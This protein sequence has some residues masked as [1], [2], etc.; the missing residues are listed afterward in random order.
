[1]EP[2][3]EALKGKWSQEGKENEWTIRVG[4][5][6]SGGGGRNTCVPE[7]R[8]VGKLLE[9]RNANVLSIGLQTAPMEYEMLF[10]YFEL[11]FTLTVEKTKNRQTYVGMGRGVKMTLLRVQIA[12]KSSVWVFL[13]YVVYALP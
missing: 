12:I 2:G 4:I 7:E 9:I 3:D 1:M 10:F 6:K 11:C 13:S 5:G 8:A